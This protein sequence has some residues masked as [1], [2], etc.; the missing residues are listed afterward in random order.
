MIAFMPAGLAIGEL[1]LRAKNL[2]PVLIVIL[3]TC[4]Q[5]FFVRNYPVDSPGSDSG[6]CQHEQRHR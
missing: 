2:R 5:F 4:A 3:A 1:R 6:K